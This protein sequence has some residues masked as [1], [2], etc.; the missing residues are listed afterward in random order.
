MLSGRKKDGGN[1]TSNSSKYV[2]QN[3][4][5]PYNF[6]TSYLTINSLN[7]TD[8]GNYS[9]TLKNRKDKDVESAVLVV[10]GKRSKYTK[11]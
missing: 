6:K 11:H 4:D 9:C 3:Q 7:Y 5:G 10:H 2:I 1:Q 8:R